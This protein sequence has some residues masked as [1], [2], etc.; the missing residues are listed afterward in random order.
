MD[1]WG[2]KDCVIVLLVV[3]YALGLPE[4]LYYSGFQSALVCLG[5]ALVVALL[6]S[7]LL[8][9]A[10]CQRLTTEKPFFLT[11]TPL[12]VGELR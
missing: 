1:Y 9:P 6:T 3:F 4:G 10:T 7:A 12:E 5:C 11:I 2:C 8:V